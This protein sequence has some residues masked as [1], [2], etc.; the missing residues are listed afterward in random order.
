MLTIN[1]QSIRFRI[2]AVIVASIVCGALL[3]E[4]VWVPRMTALIV[5]ANSR[6]LRREVEILSDGILPF[7]LS[8][9][10]GAVYETLGSVEN[11]YG[12]WVQIMLHSAD[13][14]LLYPRRLEETLGSTNLISETASIQFQ[15]QSF[16]RL[17]V[18]ADL[19]SEIEQFQSEVWRMALIGLGIVALTLLAI[20]FILDK[21][22]IRCLIK[23]ADRGIAF[24]TEV[25]I[26]RGCF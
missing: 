25:V 22:F 26:E 24:G 3:F 7:L 23:V 4:H 11:R 1:F 15:G 21:L 8:N 14:R 9:Q 18:I 16:G 10:I 2:S 17:T 5:D 13:E 12:N 20:L 19:E 6:E